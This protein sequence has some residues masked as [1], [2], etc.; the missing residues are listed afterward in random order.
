MPLQY[1]VCVRIVFVGYLLEEEQLEKLRWEREKECAYIKDWFK[2][3]V[4]LFLTWHVHKL[5]FLVNMVNFAPLLL[6][7]KLHLCFM[8]YSLSVPYW[9]SYI[10]IFHVLRNT[11]TDNQ[12][13]MP[14]DSS[15]ASWTN[16]T[17]YTYSWKSVSNTYDS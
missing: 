11:K 16:S 1:F 3:I 4:P 10:K 12:N 6:L 8:A 2:P 14:L 15:W 13:K 7:A 17:S 9:P 5:K